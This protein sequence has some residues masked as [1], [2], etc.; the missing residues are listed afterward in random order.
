MQNLPVAYADAGVTALV[1]LVA[2]MTAMVL[3]LSLLVDS[4]FI[5]GKEA[6]TRAREF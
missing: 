6:E 2:I 1:A 3:H 5:D 4:H